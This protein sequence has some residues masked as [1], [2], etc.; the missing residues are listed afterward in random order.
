MIVGVGL[1]G[2]CVVE[3]LV[4]VGLYLVVIDENVCWG[5]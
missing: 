1:V 3:V 2:V 4:D 5:G